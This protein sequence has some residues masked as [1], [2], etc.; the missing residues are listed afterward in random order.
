MSRLSG[1]YFVFS[2]G[3]ALVLLACNGS[4]PSRQKGLGDS[5]NNASQ[6]MPFIESTINEVVPDFKAVHFDNRNMTW[7]AAGAFTMKSDEIA[8]VQSA[9]GIQLAGFWIDDHEVTNAQFALFVE[10]TGYQT[11][12]E[13]ALDPADF[14]TVPLDML[15]PGSYVFSRSAIVD[16]NSNGV[17]VAG[18]N[19]RHPTGPLSTIKEKENDPV[20]QVSY[21]DA[22]AYAKW[23]G[24]RLPTEV[25]WK[26]A[27]RRG[28]FKYSD[29]IYE[30][31]F[32]GNK[33]KGEIAAAS[34]YIS[35]RCVG[36][37]AD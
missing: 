32:L 20:V 27:S 29:Q 16:I 18:A 13:R 34:N 28:Q 15:V 17:F 7:V 12:A 4:N 24:K 10:A 22:M 35:F 26:Y 1:L 23:I 11:F 36:D 14:P 31:H 37:A 3:F 25:E 33:R 5:V 2:V 9:R 21:E 8:D 19:W 30:Y 6:R